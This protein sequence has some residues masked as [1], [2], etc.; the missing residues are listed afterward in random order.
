[1]TT[2]DKFK[3]FISTL[4]ERLAAEGESLISVTANNSTEGGAFIR[5]TN[6]GMIDCYLVYQ[7]NFGMNLIRVFS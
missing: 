6:K 2:P 3:L 5:I 1:M 4:K 7:D